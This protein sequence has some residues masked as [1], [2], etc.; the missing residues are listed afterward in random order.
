MTTNQLPGAQPFST[1]PSHLLASSIRPPRTRATNGKPHRKRLRYDSSITQTRPTINE[2]TTIQPIP[3]ITST[4]QTYLPV[5]TND[6]QLLTLVPNHSAWGHSIKSKPTNTLRIA[7]RNINSLPVSLPNSKHEELLN[8]ITSNK[9]DIM[10][11]V[12]T[13]L[14]WPH[15]YIEHRPYARFKNGFE[16]VHTTFAYN[17]HNVSICD[18]RQAGGTLQLSLN[19]ACHRVLQSDR[20][21]SGLGR[22]SWTAYRCLN[23]KTLRILTLYRP[24]HSTNI[25]GVYSQHKI[26]LL[27]LNNDTCPR[28]QLLNDL[29]TLLAKWFEQNDLIIVMGDFNENVLSNDLTS[30]FKRFDMREIVTSPHTTTPPNTYSNGRFPIDGIFASLAINPVQS[31]YTPVKWGTNSD[32]RC[33]W[34]DLSFQEIFGS[35]DPPLWKPS[36]RRLKNDD[37]RIVTNFNKLRLEHCHSNKLLDSLIS[38]QHGM[39]NGTVHLDAATVQLNLLDNIRLDGIL[40]ADRKCRK[41][42]MG[43]IQWTPELQKIIFSIQYY[44]E[45]WASLTH[46]RT[47]NSRTLLKLRRRAGINEAV[48]NSLEASIQLQAQFNALKL[49]KKSANT[50]RKQ[51]LQEL[52]SAKAVASGKTQE[53]VILD[54]TQREHIRTVFRKIK[55]AA[56]SPRIGITQV[57]S[58]SPTLGTITHTSKESIE[59]AC[60]HENTRRFTQAYGTPSLLPEQIDLLGWTGNS[61]TAQAILAGQAQNA[62]D[63]HPGIVR[64]LP[65]I[66]TPDKIMELGK[67]STLLSKEEFRRFWLKCREYTSSGRSGLHFGH[68]KASALDDHL[69][70]VDRLFLEISMTHG[71]ILNRWLQAIDVMIPKKANSVHVTKLRT[72]MLFEAD[73]NYMNKLIGKRIMQQ[74]EKATTIAPEQYGSRK[75]KSAILHATNKQLLFDIIRQKKSNVMLLILDATACYD[76]ISIPFASISLQRIGTPHQVVKIMFETLEH[77]RHYI[78]TSFG[79]SST[80]YM[81]KLHRFHGIGQ[82]NGA[83]PTIWVMVSSPLLHRLRQEKY[84]YSLTSSVS[85]K[86][87]LFSAF[88]FVDDNDMIQSIDDSLSVT[89]SAQQALDVWVDSLVTT[90]GSI[91]AEKSLWSPLVHKWQNNHWSIVNNAGLHDAITVATNNSRQRLARLSPNKAALALGIMFSPSGQMTSHFE[92]LLTKCSTWAQKIRTSHLNREESFTALST[93]IWKTLEY[94]LLS[95]ALT[96]KQ[97]NKLVSVILSAGLP[98]SGICRNIARAPLF[99]STKFQGFGLFHPYFTQGFRKLQQLLDPTDDNTQSLVQEAV[100]QMAIESGLGMQFLNKN[101]TPFLHIITKGW[102]SCLWEFTYRLRLHLHSPIDNLYPATYDNDELLMEKFQPHVTSQELQL[103]NYCRLHLRILY[104]S[105]ILSLTGKQIRSPIW[106]GNYM[107]CR[108]SHIKWPEQPR[109]SKSIWNL[110]Q[111]ALQLVFQTDS[112]GKLK[113]PISLSS[114]NSKSWIWYYSQHDNLL[115]EYNDHT[116]LLISIWQQDPAQRRSTRQKRFIRTTRQLNGLWQNVTPCTI[117]KLNT[118]SCLIDSV[119]PTAHIVPP[120]SSEPEHICDLINTQ[121]VGSLD[122]LRHAFINNEL[123]IVSDGSSKDGKGAGAW[124]ITSANCFPEHYVVGNIPTPGLPTHQDSHRAECSGILGAL[125]SFHSLL[126]KWGYSKGKV[127]YGCDNISAL[128]YSFDTD[129]YPNITGTAPD[130]DLLQSIRRSLLQDMQY[131]WRHVKGHQDTSGKTLDFWA[132][133]N[134]FADKLATDQRLVNNSQNIL[135]YTLPNDTWSINLPSGRVYKKLRD[136][137]YEHW[138]LDPMRKFWCAKKNWSEE[139]FY[140]IAWDA[141]QAAG[142]HLSTQRRHWICKHTI[143]VCGTNS[144][145]KRWKQRDDD[146]CTRCGQV[147]TPTHVWKCPDPDSRFIWTAALKELDTWLEQRHTLTTLRDMIITSLDN[148]INSKPLNTDNNT[149]ISLQMAIGWDYFIEGFIP[150]KWIDTQQQHYLSLNRLESGKRW[151]TALIIKSWNIAWDLWE[152]RNHTTHLSNDKANKEAITT[153]LNNLF[154]Q[155]PSTNELAHLYTDAEQQKLLTATDAY[156]KAWIAAVTAHSGF[157]KRKQLSEL[158]KMQQVLRHFI[159]NNK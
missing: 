98:K 94:S 88:T 29:S 100:I 1:Q 66:S 65:Y 74:A 53:R 23:T 149:L 26:R 2:H 123:C 96:E 154:Q 112:S 91:S 138:S 10:G 84:G 42:R 52:A 136:Q 17:T 78:R 18:N 32:H 40:H 108:H 119:L 57:E 73:W 110:W 118:H 146:T 54:L 30:F 19:Q 14:C 62:S 116:H 101:P 49:L 87:N 125:F 127:T 113:T 56:G 9:I 31:G 79:D 63:L 68:F 133:L 147:E 156:K 20:D 6:K 104:T 15:L 71:I 60:M 132:T 50:G 8:D 5:G 109:P 3:E 148:W 95:T 126:S 150:T 33:I 135:F 24:V 153:E 158:T 36:A 28:Q 90:G 157:R 137:L 11:I 70:E 39:H 151:A 103:L 77:M 69:T 115:F 82:G 37:P 46:K 120:N 93:T 130:F 117:I 134:V 106:K 145:L 76:C 38:L 64:L 44:R 22:W 67:I 59:H 41:L 155:G 55:H 107:P 34:V 75:Q 4:V 89:S 80:Y 45:S 143:G 141:I 124:I 51:Y 13:N 81:K 97:C 27:E 12:E 139:T 35:P 83:G 85:G 58:T 61:T 105:D 99:S 121:I 16:H 152:H 131:K 43:N 128:R 25:G 129:K 111:R 21:P 72:I 92:H 102:I 48:S 140:S 122:Q 142:T 7:M 86:S 47:V 114:F 144:V 159:S